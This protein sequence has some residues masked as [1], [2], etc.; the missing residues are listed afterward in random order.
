MLGQK[1]IYLGKGNELGIHDDALYDRFT[2]QGSRG[3]LYFLPRRG[4]PAEATRKRDGG[5]GGAQE[6]KGSADGA[7]PNEAGSFRRQ[8]C[9]DRPLFFPLKDFPTGGVTKEKPSDRL[10][11]SPFASARARSSPAEPSGCEWPTKPAA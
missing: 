1:N 2:V 7:G 6:R 8:N 10:W 4:R 5:E 9:H 3:T 11:P